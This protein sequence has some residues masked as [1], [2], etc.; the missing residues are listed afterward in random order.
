MKS[1]KKCERRKGICF[2]TGPACAWHLVMAS[3]SSASKTAFATVGTT[4]FET[5]VTTLLSDEVLRVLAAQGFKRL[6][7]QLGRGPE[8][9]IPAAAPLEVEWY[10]F[11]PSL[12]EDMRTASLIISHAGAGSILEGMR[13]GALM[14][15]VVND[16]LMHNHQQELAEELR[17]RQH[18]LATT[19][20]GLARSLR[21]LGDQP[22]ALT[23]MPAADSTAFSRYRAAALGLGSE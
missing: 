18:L 9:T 21:E 14:L 11:K 1:Q 4:Q 17:S 12:E 7:I 19:P 8:I 15:V 3:S 10:R 22:P 5:M 23:P 6:L 2:H 20:S 13:L 16:E